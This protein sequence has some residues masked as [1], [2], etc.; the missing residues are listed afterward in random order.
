MY[1]SNTQKTDRIKILYV[2]DC[3]NNL[4]L[5]LKTFRNR[6][7]IITSEFGQVGLGILKT[8]KD[9]DV[10]ISDFN[11]PFMNGLE[12]IEKARKIKNDIPFYIISGTLETDEIRDAL[13]N[14]LIDYFFIKPL[15]K[16]QLLNEIYNY[17][18]YQREQA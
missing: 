15:D 16:S 11:M 10:V 17:Y 9:I 14:K 3:L 12:F 13:Q 4:D 18:D 8:N 2:D 6:F 5:F 1:D 7:E